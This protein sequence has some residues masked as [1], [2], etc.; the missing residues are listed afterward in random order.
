MIWNS[1]IA[2]TAID[3]IVILTIATLAAAVFRLRRHAAASIT[4]SGTILVLAG[5]FL[6]ALSYCADLVSMYV[7]PGVIG[8]DAATRFMRNLH[9]EADWFID[10]VSFPLICTGF[11]LEIISRRNAARALETS[12]ARFRSIVQDQTDY[13]VRWLPGGIRTWVN[14]PYCREFGLSEEAAVGSSLFPLISE[15]DRERVRLEVA[16]LVPEKPVRTGVHQVILPDGTEAWHEWTDRALFDA[17]GKVIE[18]Q[19]VGRNVTDRMLTEQALQESESRFRGF[20]D[21]THDWV[22]QTDNDVRIEFSNSQVFA[23]LGYTPQQV[24]EF[25][26]EKLL[27]PEDVAE[28]HSRMKQHIQSRTGWGG[29]VLRY[30]HRNGSIRYLESSADPVFDARGE[31]DGF[32]GISRDRTFE[33]ILGLLTSDLVGRSDSELDETIEQ[34]LE[35]IALSYDIDRISIW[36]YRE[37]FADRSHEWA[38]DSMRGRRRRIATFKDMPLAHAIVRSRQTFKIATLSELPPD[39]PDRQFLEAQNVKA[40]MSLPLFDENR[41]DGCAVF[42]MIT[43]ERPWPIAT[44]NELR[45]LSSK[46]AAAWQQAQATH[47]VVRRERDLVRAEELAQVGSFT[48]E[49]DDDAQYYPSGWRAHF[50]REFCSLLATDPEQASY[51]LLLDRIHP[52]D[53]DKFDEFITALLGQEGPAEQQYRIVNPGGKLVYFACRAETE[54]DHSGELA[55]IVASNRDISEQVERERKLVTA[56]KENEKLRERLQEENIQ[57]REEIRTRT[58]FE[59]IIGDSAA[60]RKCLELAA[61]AAPTDA[62]IL[63]LGETGTGKELVAKAIHELSPRRAKRLVSVNCTALPAN[64]VESELFG[65]E[66]GAFTGAA[67]RRAGRFEMADGGTLFLDEIGDLPLDLQAKLLRVLEDGTFERLG[68][69]KT[70]R[71]DVRLIAA[72]NR[73]LEQAVRDGEFRADLFYR[74]STVPIELPS[75]RERVED[76]PALAHHFVA[77][78]NA[79]LK[80]N[81]SAISTR[82][83]RYLQEREWPGNIRELE[84]FIERSMISASSAVLTLGEQFFEIQVPSEARHEADRP[85][86]LKLIERDH[87]M[88]VLDDTGWV[89][90]GDRGAATV[91]GLA[92]STLRSKMKRLGIARR[93]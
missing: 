80:K 30:R 26:I 50:S 20:V 88:Q 75:L 57:L 54:R 71:V 39:S 3:L 11:L 31:I 79:P 34:S 42:S 9:L 32:R 29:W 84:H 68:G 24:S 62:A 17:T 22:W 35:R 10:A 66:R 69:S 47:S 40:T 93:A 28:F 49:R 65:H 74:I 48:F 56:L 19:S 1:V 81:V 6:I 23:I 90:D 44:E 53:R 67:S 82:M 4:G 33:T 64:L 73:N 89:I 45:L 5:L 87:I 12:E 72:T 21:N 70:Q 60:L 41:I 52:D 2:M 14:E 18:V 38:R 43:A 51:E 7:L 27:H 59:Q 85:A 61:R 86:P 37:G 46:I 77:K 91:L 63:V 36:W 83:L 13:I 55:R 78:H 8:Q 16:K 15:D 58:E 25:T 76:I 92:P